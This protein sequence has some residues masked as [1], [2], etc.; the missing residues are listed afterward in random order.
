MTGRPAATLLHL[1]AGLGNGVANLHNARRASVPLINIVGDHATDHL[2]YDAPLTSDIVGIA[3][4]VSHWVH[5]SPGAGF[6]ADRLNENRL[7]GN[8]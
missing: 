6:V 8:S 5:R 2:K 1:G 7:G 4:P 3:R